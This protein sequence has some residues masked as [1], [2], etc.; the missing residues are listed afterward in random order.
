MYWFRSQHALDD[1]TDCSKTRT[2]YNLGL[3]FCKYQK[4]NFVLIHIDFLLLT[5]DSYEG[6]EG[7]VVQKAAVTMTP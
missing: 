1:T 7:Q 2:R 4:L 3:S 5:P 6:N